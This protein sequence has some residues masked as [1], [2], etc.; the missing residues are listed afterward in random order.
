MNLKLS[1]NQIWITNNQRTENKNWKE[2]KEIHGAFTWFCYKWPTYIFFCVA[3]RK[4][5]LD[6]IDRG[7]SDEEIKTKNRFQLSLV[8]YKW[9]RKSSETIMAHLW[10]M[11]LFCFFLSFLCCARNAELSALNNHKKIK[12]TRITWFINM[13][14]STGAREQ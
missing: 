8:T 3:I 13:P 12:D 4:I 10:M 14:T 11:Y 7:N 9:R 6:K 5:S 1:K 2:S